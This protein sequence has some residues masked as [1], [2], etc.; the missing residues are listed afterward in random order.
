MTQQKSMGQNDQY[1][2]EVCGAS[3][4]TEAELK[5]HNRNLHPQ[6]EGTPKEEPNPMRRY[7]NSATE[8]ALFGRKDSPGTGLRQGVGGRAQCP[9]SWIKKSCT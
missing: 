2:C 4:R 7:A 8:A 1:K 5:E 3:F 6:T 9:G